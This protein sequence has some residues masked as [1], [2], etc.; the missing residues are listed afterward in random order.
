MKPNLGPVHQRGIDGRV[1]CGHLG[2]GPAP[3][4][5]LGATWSCPRPA[6]CPVSC[7]YRYTTLRLPGIARQVHQRR[8]QHFPEAPRREGDAGTTTSTS[9][10]DLARLLSRASF[11]QTRLRCTAPRVSTTPPDASSP[12][13]RTFD[14]GVPKFGLPQDRKGFVGWMGLGGS[15]MQWH[16]ELDIGFGY[17]MTEMVQ[18]ADA[19]SRSWWLQEALLQCVDG[20]DQR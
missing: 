2:V 10:F 14:R 19:N 5:R 18:L 12:D 20:T 1:I 16:P 9:S 11:H 15:A 7:A 4:G 3:C 6:R 13:W 17:C 8:I